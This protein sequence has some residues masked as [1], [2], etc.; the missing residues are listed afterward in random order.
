ML[1]Q[2]APGGEIEHV[3]L[4][5]FGIA[6]SSAALSGLTGTGVFIG[7][8]EYM[9]P[10]Q[11]ESREVS[12][13]T[14]VYAL[15]ATVYQCLTGRLPFHRELAE[16]ARPPVGALD[17]VSEHPPGPPAGAG[18]CARQG[19]RAPPRRPL[20]LLRGADGRL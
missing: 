12:A 8:I 1:I 11:M 3:Y 6:K 10:E 2:R 5:D 16:G 17:P 9:A 15:G 18:R 20:C 19:A 14:D 4:T 13:Q 7:T